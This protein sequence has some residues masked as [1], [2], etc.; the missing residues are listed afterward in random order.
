[1]ADG[2]TSDNT[3]NDPTTWNGFGF[4]GEGRTSAFDN[5]SFRQLT[6]SAR[7]L[8]FPATDLD[9]TTR[10]TLQISGQYFTRPLNATLTGDYTF[11]DGTQS[12]SIGVG[13]TIGIRFSPTTEG[14][15]SGSVTFSDEQMNEPLVV[16]LTGT[17]NAYVAPTT[18][19]TTSVPSTS[20][21]PTSTDV[22]TT[23][24][25]SS[26]PPTSSPS[27]VTPT[28]KRQ[29]STQLLPKSLPVVPATTLPAL[30]TTT[31][32][33]T[34]PDVEESVVLVNGS[35]VTS[36]VTTDGEAVDISAG[37]VVARFKALDKNGD[38]IAP[39]P[40][41]QLQLNNAVAIT[42]S[43]KGLLPQSDV[44]VWMRSTP[45]L[46][47]T[48]QVSVDG[49]INDSFNV[50]APSGE[51]RI[52]IDGLNELSQSITMSIGASASNSDT[53]STS[54]ALIIAP[55][56]LAVFG[57]VFLPPVVRRRRHTV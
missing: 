48:S 52:I 12:Q 34:I 9:T 4:H 43:A 8:N 35:A 16:A 49:T 24:A 36:K 56:A 46:L 55:L 29:Q 25:I 42:I 14:S 30:T 45:T 26:A 33:T 27:T 57:A 5:I 18:T 17:A 54:M 38:L 6:S 39:L 40:S 19:P 28:P 21:T 10:Q 15:H 7:S 53:S 23:I 51:H 2:F 31:T 20:T 22:S 13:S 50:S 32:T 37:V 41:G 3:R 47:G 1:V 44:R 11:D